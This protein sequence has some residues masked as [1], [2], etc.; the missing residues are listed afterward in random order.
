M[1]DDSSDLDPPARRLFLTVDK[2]LRIARASDDRTVWDHA[3]SAAGLVVGL[4]CVLDPRYSPLR[5]LA[6]TVYV[7]SCAAT[8]DRERLDQ[9]IESLRRLRSP[10]ADEAEAAHRGLALAVLLNARHDLLSLAQ[11]GEDPADLDEALAQPFPPRHS[12]ATSLKGRLLRIRFERYGDTRDLDA[13]VAELRTARALAPADPAAGDRL[14]ATATLGDALRARGD[15]TGSL[16]DLDEAVELLREVAETRRDRRADALTALGVALL[17]H[18]QAADGAAAEHSAAEAVRVLE[19]AVADTDADHLDLPRRHAHLGDALRTRARARQDT[20]PGVVRDLHAALDRHETA[21]ALSDDD[22]WRPQT[23][24]ALATV[25]SDL[26]R[27]TP[28]PAVLDTAVNAWRRA[29]DETP[30]DDLRHPYTLGNLCL[31]RWHRALAEGFDAGR[32]DAEFRAVAADWLGIADDVRAPAEWRALAAFRAATA[33]LRLPDPSAAVRAASKAVE[34]LPL[35]AAPSRSR[36]EQEKTLAEW[37]RLPEEAA[38]IAVEIGDSRHALELL[39]TGRAVLWSHY[40]GL[41]DDAAELR[42]ADPER[43]AALAE[44]EAVAGRALHGDAAARRTGV[45]RRR[46]ELID[47]IRRENSGLG[48]YLMPARYDEL[49]EAAADGPVVVVS[50]GPDGGFALALTDDRAAPLPIDLPG[51]TAAETGTH[52]RRLVT[53][54]NLVRLQPSSAEGHEALAECLDALLPWLWERLAGPVLDTLSL[55][56]PAGGE[57]PRLWWS[58]CGPLAVLPLH[59]AGIPT[60]GHSVLDRVVPSCT[61][62][63]ETLLRLRRAQRGR[64]GPEPPALLPVAVPGDPALSYA[65]D[66]VRAVAA[67]LGCHASPPLLGPSA[68]AGEVLRQL[69]R[70]DWVHF[71]CHG[72]HRPLDASQGGLRLYD[73]TLTVLELAQ[74]RARPGGVAYLSVCWGAQGHREL[75]GEAVHPAAALLISGYEH[76]VSAGWT[77]D[78][79]S[80]SE[81]AEAVY[82]GL[83]AD[84]GTPSASGTARALHGAVTRLRQ[85]GRE[86]RVWAPYVHF[87]L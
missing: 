43:A 24:A 70:H 84:P 71:A 16:E 3:L 56:A 35:L 18:A 17:A 19:R 6:I 61:P 45:F 32:R 40:G 64:P 36:K 26:G 85:A 7:D 48:R 38:R 22:R 60:A 47:E 27:R 62:T 41:R 46:Q 78:D 72:L 65:E 55:P 20:D 39:D 28:E 15:F 13:A 4:P 5:L 8:G 58:P 75:P 44:L 87:G 67:R 34:L 86:P 37:Q 51:L 69:P 82:A 31:E 29:Y 14:L 57:L 79:D 42:A 59:A 81:V 80:A 74:A 63:V 54:W 66:E 68:T 52:A 77:L 53:A 33:L 10:D 50:A 73:R 1:H 12:A 21:L 23:L 49:R 83:T 11:G 76:V 25:H 30:E 2:L 9:A